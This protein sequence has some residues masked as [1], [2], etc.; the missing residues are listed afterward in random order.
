MHD[1]RPRT[2]RRTTLLLGAGLAM[3]VTALLPRPSRAQ[4]TAGAGPVRIGVIGSGNIGSTIGGLWVKAGH[5][6]LFSSRN[7]ETLKGLV[8]G[9]GPLARAGTPQEATAFG[10]VVFLAV[11]Y[12]AMPGIGRDLGPALA[13]KVVLDAGNAVAS[14]DGDTMAVVREKGIGLA[15]A[16]YLPGARVVRAFNSMGV[17][18]FRA[19]AHRPGEPLAIPIAGDDADALKVASD[20]VRDAGFEPVVVG[21]LARAAE[22][23]MGSGGFNQQ[24]GARELRQRLGLPPDGPR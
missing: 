20:L 7:P 22:F 15:T 3:G 9:L 5:P 21:P 10:D 24:V 14:R 6:V 8:D 16:S 12:G 13:G 4:A 19:Q 11:P 2:T 17:G 18:V 23:A 1:H